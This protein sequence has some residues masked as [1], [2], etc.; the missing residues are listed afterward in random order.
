[1]SDPLEGQVAELTLRIG[2][3][4]RNHLAEVM[5]KLRGAPAILRIARVKAY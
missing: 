3:R 1:M 2:V 4:D 5:R